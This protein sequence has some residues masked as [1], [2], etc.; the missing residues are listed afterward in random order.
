MCFRFLCLLAC[1]GLILVVVG[2]SFHEETRTAV[3]RCTARFGWNA[4]IISESS[5][6]MEGRRVLHLVHRDLFC[7]KGMRNRAKG[8][9]SHN[10]PET[11]GSSHFLFH[12]I[13]TFILFIF[14]AIV[15]IN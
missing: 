14:I 1:P 2:Q 7:G 8:S 11:E 3:W 4:I 15:L 6:K 13:A 10:L 5:N 12:F 9:L